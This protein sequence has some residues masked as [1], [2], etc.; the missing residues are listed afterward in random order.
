[1]LYPLEASDAFGLEGL[2]DR[3]RL[4]DWLDS[5]LQDPDAKTCQLE[6][7]EGFTAE[8]YVSEPQE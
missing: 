2:P 3:A 8:L 5:W 7:L 6:K 1:M 4:L